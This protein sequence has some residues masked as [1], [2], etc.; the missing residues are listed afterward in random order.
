EQWHGAGTGAGER[1]GSRVDESKAAS[2]SEPAGTE[3]MGSVAVRCHQS[4]VWG[5]GGGEE[6]CTVADGGS[7]GLRGGGIRMQTMATGSTTLALWHTNSLPWRPWPLPPV[8]H[9]APGEDQHGGA[10]L[11]EG[12]AAGPR[13]R[14]REKAWPP[15]CGMRGSGLYS[16]TQ[17]QQW[18][19]QVKGK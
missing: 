8:S 12:Q 7:R 14:A 16:L 9:A 13:A 17:G 10:R 4:W 15:G 3:P 6:N 19:R 2:E 1:V 5:E 18:W 11:V